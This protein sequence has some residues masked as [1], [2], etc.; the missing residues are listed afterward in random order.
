MNL[1]MLPEEELFKKLSVEFERAKIPFLLIGGYAVNAYGYSRTTQDVDF[2][3]VSSDYDKAKEVLQRCG[4]RQYVHKDLC[5]RFVDHERQW[6]PLDLVFVEQE[7]FQN[8]VKEA[9]DVEVMGRKLLV[10]SAE[11]LIALKLHAIKNDPKRETKDLN[12]IFELIKV[13]GLDVSSPKF[14]DFCLKFG[15]IDLFERIQKWAGK[16]I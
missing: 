3:I 9:R 12:D 1:M 13:K 5:A 7:T 14:K 6:P 4:Y 8:V 15:N 2:M 11:H 10:P 16:R